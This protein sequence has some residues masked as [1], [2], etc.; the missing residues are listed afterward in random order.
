MVEVR[1]HG[2]GWGEEEGEMVGEL[3]VRLNVEEWVKV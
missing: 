3:E 2:K 1:E